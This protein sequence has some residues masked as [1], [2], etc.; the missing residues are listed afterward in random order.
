M[1]PF[2]RLESPGE[3]SSPLVL[4]K[5]CQSGENLNLTS[6]R[7]TLLSCSESRSGVDAPGVRH[8]LVASEDSCLVTA[9]NSSEFPFPQDMSAD[10]KPTETFGRDT[11]AKSAAYASDKLYVENMWGEIRQTTPPPSGQPTFQSNTVWSDLQVKKKLKGVA[12]TS[13]EQNK[14]TLIHS[15]VKGIAKMFIRKNTHTT[16]NIELQER[17]SCDSLVLAIGLN[18]IYG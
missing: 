16:H 12:R 14:V 17:G 9:G 3:N 7:V 6:C 5:D 10:T 11:A 13:S 8:S 15:I 2:T 18:R 4:L 1:Y